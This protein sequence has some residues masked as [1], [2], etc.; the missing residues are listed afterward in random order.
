MFFALK[1]GKMPKKLNK[2]AIL[3]S[4]EALFI[5]IAGGSLVTLIVLSMTEDR[6]FMT[7]I[8]ILGIVCV[9]CIGISALLYEAGADKPNCV[10]RFR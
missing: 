2:K 10:S 7:P 9:V 6:R 4:L 8:G 5:A 1:E 3:D